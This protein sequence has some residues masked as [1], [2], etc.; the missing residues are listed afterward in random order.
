MKL[1]KAEITML[2]ESLEFGIHNVRNGSAPYEQREAKIN[3]MQ[4]LS[5]KLTQMAKE[6]E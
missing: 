5:R 6:A 1:T 2:K 3:E 4:A